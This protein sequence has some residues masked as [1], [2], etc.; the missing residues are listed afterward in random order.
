LPSSDDLASRDESRAARIAAAGA[1]A[2]RLKQGVAADALTDFDSDRRKIGEPTRVIFQFD[3]FHDGRGQA[4]NFVRGGRGRG[5]VGIQHAFHLESGV[6][7]QGVRVVTRVM[8]Q[9]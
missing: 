3:V 6:E 8:P 9:N 4:L 2:G 7:R 5:V 1:I